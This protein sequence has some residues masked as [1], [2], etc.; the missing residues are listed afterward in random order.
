MESRAN[1]LHGSAGGAVELSGQERSR[2]DDLR[3]GARRGY[4]AAP[5]QFD[6]ESQHPE[7]HSSRSST[8]SRRERETV[9]MQEHQD[10]ITAFAQRHVNASGR[11]AQLATL[12]TLIILSQV[13]LLAYIIKMEGM[14]PVSENPTYG[15]SAY[16]LV[17]CLCRLGAA[18]HD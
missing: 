6:E 8:R 12:S 16:A 5:E 11:C 2:R 4:S 17:S 9:S 15:P 7:G 3:M 18:W 1:P 10:A 14:A 13:F